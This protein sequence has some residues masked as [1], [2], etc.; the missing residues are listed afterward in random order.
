MFLKSIADFIRKFLF[1]INILFALYSLLVYQLVF[2]ANIQHWVGGFL[3]LSF[4]LVLLGNIFFVLVWILGMS[5]KAFL[6]IGIIL[7]SYPVANRTFK[8]KSEISGKPDF[9]LLSYNTMYSDIGNFRKD[10]SNGI[11]NGISEVAVASNADIKCFQEIYNDNKTKELR[12]IEKLS[13]EYPFYVYMHSEKGNDKGNGAIGL[14][15]VSKF[16]IL[17]KQEVYWKTNN[18]G[19]L[20]TDI[21]IKGDTIRVIN[22]QLKSMGIRVRNIIDKD[23]KIDKKE[24]RSVLSKLKHGFIDRGQE[25]GIL[26]AWI[27]ESPHPVILAGDLN[28]LPYG[29]A[30]GKLRSHLNNSF[31]DAG[32]GFG[33][34][35][36][37]I[38]NFLRIDNQFYDAKAFKV[39]KFKTLNEKKYSD[40]YPIYAEYEI[41]R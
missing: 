35:Y 25:V 26:E 13:K 14:T 24:T 18:N 16:P 3:M 6:S 36:R 37:K 30:Y 31:E 15:T 4:P 27:L 7:L 2:S 23:R 32:S 5:P 34:T 41:L 29:Y 21:L 39:I 10:N 20:A 11:T 40:H 19:L 38:L 9:S 1:L 12:L 22:F 28:E 17:N 8:F 33:F